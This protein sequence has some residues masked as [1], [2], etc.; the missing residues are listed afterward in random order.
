MAAAAIALFYALLVK[1]KKTLV[2]GFIITIVF[3]GAVYFVMETGHESHELFE[4]PPLSTYIGDEGERLMELHE[5]RAEDAS[6]VIYVTVG[7]AILGLFAA[8]FYDKAQFWV[9]GATLL[10]VIASFLFALWTADAGGKINHPELRADGLY[11]KDIDT[12][13]DDDDDDGDTD[14]NDDHESGRHH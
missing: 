6:I 4:E 11:L 10:L 9:G 13:D 5:E 12:D 2:L 1:E 8:W 3:G 14:T 7:V